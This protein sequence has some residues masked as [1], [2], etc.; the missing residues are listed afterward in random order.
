[1]GGGGQ[2]VGLCT[3]Y[4]AQAQGKL[5]VVSRVLSGPSSLRP[6]WGQPTFLSFWVLL[7]Y[8]YFTYFLW[9]VFFIVRVKFQLLNVQRDVVLGYRAHVALPCD[10]WPRVSSHLDLDALPP[11]FTNG[12]DLEYKHVEISLC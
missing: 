4:S 10:T 8:L 3:P 9:V 11:G 6:P 7:L 5:D 2:P 12:H 1:M